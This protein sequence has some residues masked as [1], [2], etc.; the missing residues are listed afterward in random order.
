MATYHAELLLNGKTIAKETIEADNTRLAASAV[1]NK[2]QAL[3][4]SKAT[5]SDTVAVRLLD[6]N[7]K[8]HIETRQAWELGVE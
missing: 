2:H 3:L 1:F 5:P 4:L 8:A 6:S 7:N